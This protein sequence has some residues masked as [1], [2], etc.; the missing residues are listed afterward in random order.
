MSDATAQRLHGH[1]VIIDWMGQPVLT[2]AD[3]W[4]DSPKAV[5]VGVNPAPASVT[6]GHYYQGKNGRTAM[7][8]L[9]AAGV[10]PVADGFDDDAAL[11]AGIAFTD[12]V[13]R[14]TTNAKALTRSELEHGRALLLTELRR[15]DVPLIVCVFKPAAEAILGVVGPPGMQAVR[16]ETGSAVFRMPG[17]Y[18]PLAKVATSMQELVDFLRT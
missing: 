9:R 18:D 4:P 11:A 13:K 3:L 5:V 12:I 14:P 16:T 17:P 6:A 8:R 1:Q 7:A 10:V 2:L 15:R